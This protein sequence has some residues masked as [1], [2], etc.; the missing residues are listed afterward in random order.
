MA[1]APKP[2]ENA[3]NACIKLMAA[4]LK[5]HNAK[6]TVEAEQPVDCDA[7]LDMIQAAQSVYSQF[8]PI[9]RP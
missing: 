9:A 2:D 8:C 5:E 7:L 1:V 6:V 3:L 4:L